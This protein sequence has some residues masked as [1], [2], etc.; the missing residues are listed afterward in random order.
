MPHPSFNL[1]DEPWIPCLEPDGTT[2][3]KSMRHVLHQAHA[4][5]EVQDPSPMVTISLHRL[6]LAVV[7]RIFR[8]QTVDD[9]WSIW[10]EGRFDPGRV[11]DYLLS[12][13]IHPRFD[14]FDATRPF[15]Q[16]GEFTVEK[17]SPVSQLAME[18]VSGNNPTLFDHRVD[19]SVAGISP[20]VAAR[21]LLA[22]QYTSIGFGQS[23][24]PYLHGKRL[25]THRIDF[26]DAPLAR[27]AVLDMTGKSAFAT[28][29]LNALVRDERGEPALRTLGSPSW[30][31]ES[32]PEAGCEVPLNGYLDYL[33]W[34]SRW[35]RLIPEEEDSPEPIIRH[36]M[37]CQGVSIANPPLDP[38][39]RYT[40]DKK[41]GWR[42]QTLQVDRALWRDSYAW[43][44]LHRTQKETDRFRSPRPLQQ[45]SL[46]L[47]HEVLDPRRYENVPFRVYGFGTKPNKA[48]SVEF[49]RA[50]SMS[51]PLDYFREPRHVERLK[52][53]LEL[54]ERGANELNASIRSL[55]HKLFEHEEGKGADRGKVDSFAKHLDVQRRYWPGLE[56]PFEAL[57]KQ[58]PRGDDTA[59]RT[60]ASALVK[61]MNDAFEATARGLNRSGR[62]LRAVTAARSILRSKCYTIL[63][64]ENLLKPEED[65]V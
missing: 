64:D 39:K 19:S 4:F 15:F 58:L 2:S 22:L 16:V 34:P 44:E 46:L 59:R 52:D 50:E 13:E 12:P 18:E 55:A 14:L 32:I 57:L 53:A 45:L 1:V 7:H 11:D 62:E 27:G 5:P 29:M 3:L 47:D 36:V 41:E 42:P 9:W 60:W 24:K 30:E 43:L 17:P 26:R 10:S 65:A 31:W 49:W 21:R 33:T 37:I 6:L 48:A 8:V 56:E 35:V 63:K 40:L 28:L 38:F 23:S 54:A 51:P 25:F 61:R 20:D